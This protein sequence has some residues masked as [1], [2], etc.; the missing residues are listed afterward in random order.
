MAGR[1]FILVALIVAAFGVAPARQ[2]TQPQ[3]T[4]AEEEVRKLERQWLDAYEQHD[5][6]A[7]ERIVADDFICDVGHKITS[8]L[9]NVC[10]CG[11][12]ER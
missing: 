9:L 3:L 4:N 5:A 11:Y 6:E 10:A 12:Q 8:S 7:M 2:A 1:V